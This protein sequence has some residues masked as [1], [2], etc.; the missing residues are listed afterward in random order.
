MEGSVE[1]YLGFFRDVT[2]IGENHM[3]KNME[4]EMESRIA[5]G[6]GFTLAPALT[7]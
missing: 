1:F 7:Q 4:H 2:P 6:F 3:E 5:K